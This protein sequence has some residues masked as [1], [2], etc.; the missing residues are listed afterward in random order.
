MACWISLLGC[1]LAV[2]AKVQKVLIKVNKRSGFFSLSGFSYLEWKGLTVRQ[3]YCRIVELSNCRIGASQYWPGSRLGKFLGNHIFRKIQQFDNVLSNRRTVELS[4]RRFEI[5]PV[6][7]YASFRESY[8]QENLPFRQNI[9]GLLIL[10][11]ELN[12]VFR[13]NNQFGSSAV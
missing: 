6:L 2:I 10:S 11:K 8:F 7:N 5:Y 9:A 3:F 4:N 12:H 1:F 13:G